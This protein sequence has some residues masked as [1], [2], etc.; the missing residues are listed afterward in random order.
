MVHPRTN[1]LLHLVRE[2]LTRGR[3]RSGLPHEDWRAHPFQESRNI[4]FSHLLYFK[5]VFPALSQYWLIL[6]A[7]L[8][9]LP[10]SS[11]KPVSNYINF[12]RPQQL[13]LRG[14]TY[15]T[16]Q[17]TEFPSRCFYHSSPISKY[18]INSTLVIERPSAYVSPSC[19]SSPSA[20]LRNRRRCTLRCGPA[21]G[22]RLPHPS[23]GTLG[24]RRGRSMPLYSSQRWPLLRNELYM[25]LC[26]VDSLGCAVRRPWLNTLGRENTNYENQTSS[27]SRMDITI[28]I[29]L[30]NM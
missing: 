3:L 23:T 28:W 13:K 10:P 9:Y 29:D 27:A 25:G 21:Q 12:F 16:T 24:I 4:L 7:L 6:K 17:S 5:N 15:R 20:H 18:G 19:S 22:H 11:D 26:L 30:V 14:A 1:N 2:R 8:S